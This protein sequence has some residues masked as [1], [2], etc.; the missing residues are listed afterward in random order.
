MGTR[1]QEIVA[2]LSRRTATVKQLAEELG[3]RVAIVVDDLGHI[4][5]SLGRRLVVGQARCLECGFAMSRDRRFTA[6]S[7][8]PRCRSE[9]TS[10]PELRVTTH[11]G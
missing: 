11:D 9:L 7:R 5:R 2:V 6:P 10:E 8:C 3:V 1:R 4:R